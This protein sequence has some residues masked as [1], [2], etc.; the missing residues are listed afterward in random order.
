MFNEEVS[1]RE[2]PTVGNSWR[3]LEGNYHL[4]SSQDTAG[5]NNSSF[6][7]KIIA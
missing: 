4:H 7:L 1:G 6:P 3:R 2:A 5:M